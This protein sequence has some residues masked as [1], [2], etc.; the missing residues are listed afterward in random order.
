MNKKSLILAFVSI[1]TIISMVCVSSASIWWLN[2]P[3][4]PNLLSK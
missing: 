3:K 2:Q 4:T 1:V